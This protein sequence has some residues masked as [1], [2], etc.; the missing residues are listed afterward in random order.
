MKHR[1]LIPTKEKKRKKKTKSAKSSVEVPVIPEGAIPGNPEL[2]V[3]CASCHKPKYFYLD[4]PKK[5]VQCN[6]EFVFYA[7]E[8]KYWYEVLK[9]RFN[10]V[11]IRCPSC[12]KSKRSEAVLHLQLTQ[13]H[14]QYK[15]SP[16]DPY[17][18]LAI[19]E[20]TFLL[21]ERFQN[22]KL[23][24]AITLCRKAYN[25][26]LECVEAIFWEAR[27][28]ELMGQPLK[29]QGLYEKFLDKAKNLPRCKN[30]SRQAKKQLSHLNEI[31][32]RPLS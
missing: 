4:I 25:T 8:Q 10:S 19:V 32:I 22:V 5:C 9:F 7:K 16:N 29:A 23:S 13:C 24:K 12:R 6:E 11:A 17:V 26:S 15:L 28:K 18:M 31:G 30:M 20:I 3:F 2:Q 21:Y 27:I 14:E 1:T